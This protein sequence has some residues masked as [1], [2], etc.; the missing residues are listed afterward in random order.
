MTNETFNNI[1]KLESDLNKEAAV[2][3]AKIRKNFEELGI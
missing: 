3:A 1:E 2:L